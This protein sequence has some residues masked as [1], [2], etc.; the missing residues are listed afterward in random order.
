MINKEESAEVTE[1]SIENGQ[2]LISVVTPTLRRP[3]EVAELLENLSQQTL[4]PFE[5]ILVDGAPAG[6]TETEQVVASCKESLP[7][8][9]HYF[10]HER[11]TAIQ[12]NVGIER[13]SG[14]L[15]ALIDDDI[16]L[17]PDFLRTVAAVFEKEKNAGG[18]VGYRT[19]QHFTSREAQRWRWYRK[20]NLLTTYEPGKYDYQ[21]GY[22]INANLQPPFS[23]VR[24]VDFMTTSCAVWRREVF[25]S[26][27]RFD[28]FFRDFGVLEDAHFSLRAGRQW[29]LFQC[30]DARCTHLH[31]PNG[32]TDSRRIGYKC[33]VNY[34]Y[35]FQDIVRPLTWHHKMRFWRFQAF[36]LL[37]VGASAVRRRR[38]TDLMELRGRLEG[39][40]AVRRG[41]GSAG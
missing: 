36:E 40:L 10:R 24:G 30:G 32:R 34:Y 22:P 20:L 27:L 4:L 37:R 38:M 18:V 12:R 17:E 19:N 26:G 3:V 21:S 28:P 23:G 2:V 35:V 9:L 16:R 14:Q 13:A 39:I 6:E 41:I 29:Q 15:I 33:V 5:V 1:D 11:G 31:S 7:F 8:R 25:D